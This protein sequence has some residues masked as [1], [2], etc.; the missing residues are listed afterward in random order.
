ME[1]ITV[2]EKSVYGIVHMY[3]VDPYFSGLINGLTGKKTVSETDLH[4][5]SGMGF[6]V[7]VHE[8]DGTSR[9]I[10]RKFAQG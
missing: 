10:L 9:K 6:D 3:V 8:L 1:I 7:I 5:I 4:S 2:R